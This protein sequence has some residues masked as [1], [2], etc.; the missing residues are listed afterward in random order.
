MTPVSMI[1]AVI[2]LVLGFL[3][4]LFAAL[5]VDAT[6][7]LYYSNVMQ[8]LSPLLSA[9]LCYRTMADFPKGSP[10]RKVWG[11][12]G[13]GMLAW[14]IGA[15]LFSSYPLLNNGAETPY[16]Y[17]SDIGYLSL[18]PLVVTALLLMKSTLGVASPLWGKMV[19]MILFA[20]AMVLSITANWKGLFEEG[21]I[22]PLVS[23]CYTVFDPALLAI[24]MVVASALY[25][26]VAGKAWWYV[27]A[28]LVLYFIGNQSYTY[29][30]FTKQYATGSPI[31]IFWVLGFGM[32]AMA[33][34]MNHALF[35][36]F[37]SS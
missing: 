26:G 31:D 20:G 18:V 2:W 33:A 27:L 29:L 1:L 14:G 3:I 17:Y 30:V 9:L 37:R 19:S 35:K 22:L 15:I 24:T 5:D 23:L 32:V 6:F 16:P 4:L 28:G 13:S 10:M 11:F 36:G 12:L 21:I 7:R 34:M 25:G 8:T